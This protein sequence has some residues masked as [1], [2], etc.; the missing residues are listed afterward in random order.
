MSL[1]MNKK[2]KVTAYLLWFFL[3]F[4]GAHNFYTK[5][6]IRGLIKLGCIPVFIVSAINNIMWL[7][8]LSFFS[9]IILWII[10]GVTLNKIINI[11]NDP[12][13]YKKIVDEEIKN[14][15]VISN[16]NNSPQFNS[17]I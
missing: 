7:G 4:F 8:L 15:F 10:D 6:K 3:G 5:T 17:E 2:S 11:Y 16:E 14:T 1:R 12:D 13:F 9:L